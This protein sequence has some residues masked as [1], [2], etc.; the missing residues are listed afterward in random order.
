[1]KSLKSHISLTLALFAILFSI[2][3][4]TLISRVIHNY[5]E[6]LTHNYSMIVLSHATL[7]TD[8]ILQKLSAFETIKKLSN[9]SI[10]N[11]L[12]NDLDEK[13]ITL[14]KATL[15]NFYEIKFK[16]FPNPNEIQE[17]KERLLET[18]G[19][20]QVESFSNRHDQVFRLLLLLKSISYIFGTIIII[21]S[22]LLILKEMR[23]WQFNHQDRM[24]IMALFGAPVWLRSAV[25]FKFALFDAIFATILLF[26]TFIGLEHAPLVIEMKQ[27]VSTDIPLIFAFSDTIKL[28]AISLLTAL[29]L[30]LS[31]VLKKHA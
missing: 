20:F 22:I 6:K 13:Q 15:P 28:L 26:L 9:Q 11:E 7:N 24:H 23:L 16:H 17:A 8:A 21:I 4:F 25:L 30:A 14:L 12:H 1:M 19:I 18:E 10:L 31:L 5:E 29:S 27:A 2:Q 3:F